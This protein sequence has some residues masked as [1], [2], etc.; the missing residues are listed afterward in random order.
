MKPWAKQVALASSEASR[1]RGSALPPTPFPPEGMIGSGEPSLHWLGIG[2]HPGR[3]WRNEG[4][5]MTHVVQALEPLTQ[6][7]HG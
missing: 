1:G 6:I 7:P 5:Q 3:D 4:F 2:G